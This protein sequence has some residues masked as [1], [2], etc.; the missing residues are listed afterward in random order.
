MTLPGKRTA[1]HVHGRIRD[2]YKVRL[3]RGQAEPSD[4]LLSP[5]QVADER[6]QLRV[7][8][9]FGEMEREMP[10]QI[11]RITGEAPPFVTRRRVQ[12]ADGV[13]ELG[14]DGW[15]SVV[16]FV[17]EVIADYVVQLECGWSPQARRDRESD[18][19]VSARFD[20]DVE[21]RLALHRQLLSEKQ[22][23]V[24]GPD[25]VLH[26][27]MDRTIHHCQQQW[28]IASQPQHLRDRSRWQGWQPATDELLRLG[29]LHLV[30]P[31]RLGVARQRGR[32][33]G[34][35]QASRVG[36]G[37]H[38][39]SKLIGGPDVVDDEQVGWERIE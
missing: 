14:I 30:D 21:E 15:K 36:A 35:D 20:P 8:V 16:E 29:S 9:G 11:D 28:P 2:S 3:V 39:G 12:G 4:L 10:P 31:H 25:P 17:P 26:I 19:T 13:E 5:P 24:G 37:E 38:E 18:R 33:S 6:L 27:S 22:R 32:I 34:R 23:G 7:L 1:Q